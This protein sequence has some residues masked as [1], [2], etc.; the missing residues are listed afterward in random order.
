MTHSPKGVKALRKWV[1]GGAATAAL[2]VGA[3][4]PAG[5]QVQQD[6][7]VTSTLAT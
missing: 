2:F 5:A 1:A 6:G 3:A 7:L 4:V